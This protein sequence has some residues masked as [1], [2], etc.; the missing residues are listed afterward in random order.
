MV[1]PRNS[2][3]FFDAG[4]LQTPFP[5]SSTVSLFFF[6]LS[7]LAGLLPSK[8]ASGGEKKEAIDVPGLSQLGT[9]GQFQKSQT[10]ADYETSR[11][12]YRF[13]T[14]L[15]TE[16]RLY[17]VGNYGGTLMSLGDSSADFGHLRDR[18]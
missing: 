13:L 5:L 14:D 7:P 15:L 16:Y 2:N 4:V 10:W 17:A 1:L 8:F 12:S 3:G 11:F 9:N 6:C 18:P